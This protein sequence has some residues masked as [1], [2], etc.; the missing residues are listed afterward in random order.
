MKDKLNQDRNIT[1]PSNRVKNSKNREDGMDILLI[2]EAVVVSS[3]NGRWPSPFGV[4]FCP[5][6]ITLA[7]QSSLP[8][9]ENSHLSVSPSTSTVVASLLFS[10]FNTILSFKILLWKRQLPVTIQLR[11][12]LKMIRAKPWYPLWRW[13]DSGDGFFFCTLERVYFTL[14]ILTCGNITVKLES[15]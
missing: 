15:R 13:E 1:L 3:I 6:T 10:C 8:I 14:G 7:S 4:T 11:N 12:A 9:V 5:L 2:A